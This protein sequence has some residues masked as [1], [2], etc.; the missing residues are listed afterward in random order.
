MF[1]PP[2][3]T[4]PVTDHR[5]TVDV[6]QA[7]RQR[8]A[9]TVQI[10]KSKK[11]E[12]LNR[13][14]RLE[15]SQTSTVDT[16]INLANNNIAE[17]VQGV[18]SGDIE[19]QKRY[20]LMFR[21]LLSM[22]RNPPIDIVIRAGVV[23]KFVE[24]LKTSQDSTLVFEAAWALTNIA[25]GT[26]E[27]TQVVIDAGAIPVFV[28]LLNHSMDDVRE[29]AVWALGNIAGDSCNCRDLVLSAGALP[30]LMQQIKKD[31]KLTMLRNATWTLS[32]FC[33]GKPSPDFGMVRP[34]LS[35]LAQ[36]IYADDTEILTDACWALSYLS[37][38]PND[39]IQAVI[40]AQVVQRCV[41][42]LGHVEVSVQTP[43]L[44]TVGNIVTGDDMQTQ[45]VLGTGALQALLGLLS[46]EKKGIRKEACWT[47]S[48]ITAGNPEQIQLVINAGIF[49]ALIKMLETEQFEIQKEAAWA[50]S[51]ASAGGT[52]E[53]IMY[54]VQEG[55]IKPLCD[56]LTVPDGKILL[57]ALEGLEN[58]LKVGKKQQETTNADENIVARYVEEADGVSKIENLQHHGDNMVYQKAARILDTYYELED[59]AHVDNFAP[60]EQGGQFG[61]GMDQGNGG[62]N[63]GFNFQN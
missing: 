9:T 8:E 7:R 6:D 34:A 11:E 20:T 30:A 2:S 14:R 16:T 61:F 4:T 40:E 39:R 45:V 15:P 58:V 23:P 5:A 63:T 1:G 46:S 41:E 54:L 57:V 28:Q 55:C 33:R 60:K 26:S 32:N 43:A 21:K 56:L 24:F 36:L 49:P 3:T 48:N 18:N 42:L 47:I 44:R 27:H 29:Q 13:R 17:M 10:R 25:S 22:E 38:G 37:D 35:S 59:E 52:P 12:R 62:G 51:N 50:V 31:A 53:Q 19:L